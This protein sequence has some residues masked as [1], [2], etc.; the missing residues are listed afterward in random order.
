M[1]LELIPNVLWRFSLVYLLSQDCIEVDDLDFSSVELV[2]KSIIFTISKCPS[3]IPGIN[4][5]FRLLPVYGPINTGCGISISCLVLDFRLLLCFSYETWCETL[6][7]SS[8]HA[9]LLRKYRV[10]HTFINNHI[11]VLVN[12]NNFWKNLCNIVPYQ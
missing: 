4:T 6:F 3:N 8:D 11:V 12:V 2:L 5:I 7:C 9:Y 10:Q 1:F